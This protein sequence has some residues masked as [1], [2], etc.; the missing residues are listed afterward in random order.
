MKK[1][2]SAMILPR[3]MTSD[4]NATASG[5]PAMPISVASFASDSHGSGFQPPRNSSVNTP[6]PMI[7]CEY[8]A[9]KKSDHLN[10]PYSVWKP[11]TRSD[12]DSGMSNGWRFVSAKSDTRKIGRAHV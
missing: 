11:P 9:T 1:K 12:S 10:A 8:S 4:S 7:M 5:M 6:E 3:K 2:S